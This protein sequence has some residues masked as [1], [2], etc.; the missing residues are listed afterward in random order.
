M[1]SELSLVIAA[2]QGSACYNCFFWQLPQVSRP[3]LGCPNWGGG[4]EGD[5]CC[6][7]NVGSWYDEVSELGYS[8]AYGVE[9]DRSL[10]ANYAARADCLLAHAGDMWLTLLH[11]LHLK[12][13]LIL[14]SD[15]MWSDLPHPKHFPT[16]FFLLWHSA[17]EI[18][19]LLTLL[20]CWFLPL[21]PLLLMTLAD[22]VILP[23]FLPA[24][25]LA[26]IS[27]NAA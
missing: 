27:L 11:E 13:E 18:W 14:Q 15:I 16:I 26:M 17:L 21:S 4:A 20:D 6:W 12:E 7:V 1:V 3:G 2:S 5:D 9:S 8:T 25:W 23:A 24:S 19:S 10:D 22:A